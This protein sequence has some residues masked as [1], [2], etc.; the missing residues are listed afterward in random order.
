MYINYREI[1][2]ICGSER[3]RGLLTKVFFSAS[4][5]KNNFILS[6]KVII[7][8]YLYLYIYRN[9][10]FNYMKQ[11]SVKSLNILLLFCLNVKN[12]PGSIDTKLSV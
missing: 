3:V 5:L 7:Y 12:E 10:F 2:P 6:N 11:I 9:S 8:L 4:F 1:I